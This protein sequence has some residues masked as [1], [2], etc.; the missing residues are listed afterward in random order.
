ME[1]KQQKSPIKKIGQRSKLTI[2]S[3]KAQLQAKKKSVKQEIA[4][5]PHDFDYNAD[6]DAFRSVN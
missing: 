6:H 3:K 4:Y 1:R 5:A 2:K